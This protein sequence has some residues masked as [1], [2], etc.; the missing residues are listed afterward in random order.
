MYNDSSEIDQQADNIPYN[1]QLFPNEDPG[2]LSSVLDAQTSDH[3][4]NATNEVLEKTPNHPSSTTKNE[5]SVNQLTRSV[6]SATT[7]ARQSTTSM[8]GN[9]RN[10]FRNSGMGEAERPINSQ[11]KPRDQEAPSSKVTPA[12][13]IR[14]Y[15]AVLKTIVFSPDNLIPLLSGDNALRAVAASRPNVS[16][17]IV[18]QQQRHQV[19][20]SADTYCDTTG[21][22]TNLKEAGEVIATGIKVFVDRGM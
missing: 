13:D 12:D 5:T 1:I 20:E 14:K 2:Y 16:K 7:G 10:K 11:P 22:N 15:T 19:K 17:D 18:S 8:L 3:L 21:V 6:S 9:I 4:V